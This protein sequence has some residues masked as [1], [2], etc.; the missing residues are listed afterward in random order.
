MV[1]PQAD[2]LCRLYQRLYAKASQSKGAGV[3]KSYNTFMQNELVSHA[4]CLAA[5]LPCLRACVLACLPAALLACTS[6]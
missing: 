2:F 1:L 5:L 3:P 6:T 4:C